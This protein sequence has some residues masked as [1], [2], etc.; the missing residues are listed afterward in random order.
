MRDDSAGGMTPTVCHLDVTVRSGRHATIINYTVALGEVA[1]VRGFLNALAC[2]PQTTLPD[3][4]ERVPLE[5]AAFEERYDLG[6]TAAD[7]N[8]ARQLFSPTF[9]DWLV[10]DAPAGLNFEL[11]DGA[12]CVWTLGALGTEEKL[13]RFRAAAQRIS[14]RLREEAAET[15][16]IG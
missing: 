9:I 16:S 4:L 11:R 6:A 7:A 13:D 14:G 1:A 10:E 3:G 12:L 8:R 5:S 15:G 2:M